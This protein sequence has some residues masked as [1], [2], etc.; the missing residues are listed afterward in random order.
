MQK[1]NR[2]NVGYYKVFRS[3]KDH[4]NYISEVVSEYLKTYLKPIKHE[5]CQAG[6]SAGTSFGIDMAVLALGRMS[7]DKVIDISNDFF[8][9]LMNYISHASSDYKALFDTDVEENNDRDLWW[10]GSKLDKELYEYISPN[11][12]PS[13]EERYKKS[14]TSSIS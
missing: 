14:R 8:I 3:K 1:L 13:F 12:Y 2:V 10:S 9:D 6:I 4:D 11:I 7:E 5:A